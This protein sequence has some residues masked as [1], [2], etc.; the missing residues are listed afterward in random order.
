MNFQN[1]IFIALCAD[2]L[3]ISTDTYKRNINFQNN[4][5]NMQKK[6]TCNNHL[7]H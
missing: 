2:K 7:N 1:F 5:V 3:K 6:I 4:E